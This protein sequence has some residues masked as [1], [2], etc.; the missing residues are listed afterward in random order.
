MK[1]PTSVFDYLSLPAQKR[2]DLFLDTNTLTN[3]PANYYIDFDA[4]NKRVDS[5]LFLLDKLTNE[6]KPKSVEEVLQYFSNN[7]RA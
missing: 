7:L 1:L 6:F 3:K 4:V 5:K 2:I